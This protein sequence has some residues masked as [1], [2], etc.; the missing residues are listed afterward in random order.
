MTTLRPYQAVLL[1]ALGCGVGSA[2]VLV[3]AFGLALIWLG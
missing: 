3:G 1:T 2:L